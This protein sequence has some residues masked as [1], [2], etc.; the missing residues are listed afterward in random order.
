MPLTVAVVEPPKLVELVVIFTMVLT[1][2]LSGK[3]VNVPVK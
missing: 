1:G 3:N 2:P